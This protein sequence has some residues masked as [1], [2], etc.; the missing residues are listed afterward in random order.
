M[1][2]KCFC[3]ETPS[4]NS[5]QNF[6]EFKKYNVP[7]FQNSLFPRFPLKGKLFFSTGK[8]Y[9]HKQLLPSTVESLCFRPVLELPI[10][11]CHHMC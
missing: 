3:S 8:G 4:K 6:D 7:T 1:V 2:F 10:S 9:K 5:I 11:T